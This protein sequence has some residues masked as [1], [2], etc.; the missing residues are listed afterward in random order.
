MKNKGFTKTELIIVIAI[1]AVLAATLI[2]TFIGLVKN[3]NAQ[4]QLQQDL[5]QLSQQIE[6][7][8][9]LS[10]EEIEAKIAAQI[11][12]IQLPEGVNADDVNKAI[13]DAIAGL[14]IP[15]GGLTDTQ[16]QAIIDTAIKNIKLPEAGLSAAEVEKIVSDAISGIKLPEGGLSADEIKKIVN[17]ALKGAG[18]GL[19]SKEVQKIV[20]AAI[21][22]LKLPENVLSAADVE[23]IITEA[24][25]GI[26]IPEAGPSAA[27]VDKMIKDAIAAAI[28]GIKPGVS[29]EELKA[30]IEA[31]IKDTLAK[32]EGTYLTDEQIKELIDKAL[33]GLKPEE[34]E[35]EETTPEAPV[36][37]TVSLNQTYLDLAVGT[38]AHLSATVFDQ[39]G[40]IVPDAVIRWSTHN[41]VCTFVNDGMV[42]A[43]APG[44]A[45][46]T[47]TVEGTNVSASCYVNVVGSVLPPDPSA[48]P[49][50]SVILDKTSAALTVGD[51]TT[52]VAT[53]L[54]ADATVKAV[55]WSS[56]NTAVATVKNGVVTAVEAG[57]AIITVTTVDGAKTATCAVTVIA[58]DGA[59]RVNNA[60]DLMAALIAGKDVKLT[61]NVSV[62]GD[63]TIPANCE[64]T[65]D[66]NGFTLT[67]DGEWELLGELTVTNGDIVI[68]K[69]DDEEAIYKQSG[70]NVVGTLNLDHVDIVGKRLWNIE[71]NG[72][73]YLTDSTYTVNGG[74][75]VANSGEAVINNCTLI[76]NGV[77]TSQIYCVGG[78]VTVTDSELVEGANFVSY[79]YAGAIEAHSNSSV[80]LDNV[81]ITTSAGEYSI[82]AASTSNVVIKSGNINNKLACIPEATITIYGGTINGIAYADF[83]VD[84]D[85]FDGAGSEL[86]KGDNCWIISVEKA[87]VPTVVPVTGVTLD[88]STWTMVVG[89]R[90]LLKATVAPANATNQ[91]LIWK[92]SNNAVATVNSK[93]RVDA[94]APGTAIITV[95]TKDGGFTATCTVTV[96]PA[97]PFVK[98]DTPE[99]LKAALNAGKDAKLTADIS[100][101]VTDN[102]PFV[103]ANTDVTIDLN[104]HTLTQEGEW[105]ILGELTVVNGALVIEKPDDVQEVYQE[106]GLCVSTGTLTLENVDII[107]KRLWNIENSSNL[108][109]TNTT[110]TVDGGYGVANSGNTVITNCTIIANGEATSQIYCVGG[111][112]TVTDSDL[113]EGANFV[114]YYYMGAIEAH[115]DSSVALNNVTVTTSADEHGVFAASTSDV[116][117][118][119]GV[120]NTTLV[121]IP[122]AT[123]TIYGGTINGIAY[124]SIT[125]GSEIFIGAGCKL[126]QG[127]NCWIIAE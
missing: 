5:D 28:A 39:Y 126:T 89:N 113:V 50:Q 37:T 42:Y 112:V 107:G 22:G 1:V 103:P 18:T 45:V 62:A 63:Y 34:T 24:I 104:G 105:E 69:P 40:N 102:A 64:S 100:V 13:K 26:K 33:A 110:I 6:N 36:V 94:I 72:T 106:S 99:E 3:K 19:T 52:L 101:V 68:E 123:I 124:D 66:L 67:E 80:T 90:V 20:D 74:Y 2:P 85:I 59:V 73:L 4:E 81:N 58:N 11:A 76:A 86:T 75:G 65:L 71:N 87:P 108:Y 53:V 23:K 29:D 83:T 78:T 54:P 114:S 43:V 118:N 122:Q 116:V 46:V 115:Y 111:T 47:A 127:N 97:D 57:T 117:I 125:T 120:F 16:V 119:S 41:T 9:T 31:A 56:S 15:E 84:S 70:F 12:G 96:N 17:D 109:L 35:P 61:A 32:L 92:S 44:T 55:T 88:L 21:A 51:T 91:T 7:Q 121:C 14:K 82:F 10:I 77:A 30:A 25:A 95:T 79:Y 27:D 8:K 93:G 60:A 98:V 48:V 49:V 38:V